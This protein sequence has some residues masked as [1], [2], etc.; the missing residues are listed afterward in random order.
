[1]EKTKL[2]LKYIVVKTC[3]LVSA[4]LDFVLKEKAADCIVETL[5]MTVNCFDN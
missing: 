1:M 4:Y 2:P 5:Y 3:T